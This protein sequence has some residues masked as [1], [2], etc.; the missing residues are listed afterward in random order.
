MKAKVNIYI[1]I[2]INE[3]LFCWVFTHHKKCSAFPYVVRFVI[4]IS[5]MKVFLT[6]KTLINLYS[7][8]YID[9]FIS[10]FM[11]ISIFVLELLW[12]VVY[13]RLYTS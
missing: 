6:L 12:Y 1:S 8:I 9:Q 13:T 11:V 2:Y 7:R 5:D 4:C 10:I 3:A